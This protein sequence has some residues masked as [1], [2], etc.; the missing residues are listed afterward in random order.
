MGILINGSINVSKLPKDKL[1][2]SKKGELFYN[3]TMSVEDE[4]DQFGN[5]V[6]IWDSQTKE[7][8]EAKEKR[9]YTGNAK[10]VWT[11][12]KVAVADKKASAADEKVVPQQAAPTVDDDLPF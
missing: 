1:D 4:T 6:G 12:G 8:R 2:R 9:N 3:F 5:N 7:Q 11:D 10:V